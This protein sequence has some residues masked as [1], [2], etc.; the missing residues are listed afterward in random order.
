MANA[1]MVSARSRA[2][3]ALRPCAGLF[4]PQSSCGATATISVG[5]SCS[6]RVR[7]RCRVALLFFTGRPAGCRACQG[8]SEPTAE[9]RIAAE[10]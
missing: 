9:I 8:F 1:A 3:C 6:G 5:S 2:G 4:S 7:D 10:S